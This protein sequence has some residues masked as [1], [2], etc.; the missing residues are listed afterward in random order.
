MKIQTHKTIIL[1]AVGYACETWY[2]TLSVQH[3]LRV[4]NNY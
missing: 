4:T 3:L 2:L 1:P